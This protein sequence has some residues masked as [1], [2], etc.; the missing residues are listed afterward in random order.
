LGCP[1]VIIDGNNINVKVIAQSKKVPVSK[2]F[3][4]L[5]L[6]DNPMGQDDE[7]TPFI[8]VRKK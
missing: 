7:L 2:A 1:A 6:L 4:R 8:I 5:I 3:C